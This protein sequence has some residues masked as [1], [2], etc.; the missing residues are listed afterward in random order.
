MLSAKM[1]FWTID[2]YIASFPKDVQ[3]ILQEIR[4]TIHK[5][6]PRATEVISYGVPA[7]KQ[8][9]ILVYFA[10][11][12]N[13]IGFYPTSKPI[14]IFKKELSAYKTSRGTIRFPLDKKIPLELI[15]KIT[16]FRAKEDSEKHSIKK[17]KVNKNNE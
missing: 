5:A 11:F 14:A 15:A 6:A 7:F 1:K 4:R 17:Q 16:K 13:H 3:K 10:A 9:N 2:E 8:N 12:K